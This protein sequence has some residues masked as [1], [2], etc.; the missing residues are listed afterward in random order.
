MVSGRRL[1]VSTK[2]VRA[3][4]RTPA[5]ARTSSSN[6]ADP[7]IPCTVNLTDI[8][9]L[10]SQIADLQNEVVKIKGVLNTL[11][12]FTD[13]LTAIAAMMQPKDLMESKHAELA[14]R[15]I[16]TICTEVMDRLKCLNEVVIYNVP[17]RLPLQ[18]IRKILM[19]VCGL[20]H[21]LLSCT[22]LRKKVMKNQCPL[23]VKFDNE[24][25]ALKFLSYQGEYR[26][27]TTFLDLKLVPA[28]T[29]LQRR[30]DRLT[31][32]SAHSRCVQATCDNSPMP[33]HLSDSGTVDLDISSD[34]DT[35]SLDC[36]EEPAN[37][38]T[39][40]IRKVTSYIE[41][42]SQPANNI[43]KLSIYTKCSATNTSRSVKPEG[44]MA[45]EP[46]RQSLNNSV[47]PM[48][49]KG[50]DDRSELSITNTQRT[51]PPTPRAKRPRIRTTPPSSPEPLGSTPPA[52]KIRKAETLAPYNAACGNGL[53]SALVFNVPDDISVETFRR[54]IIAVNGIAENALQVQRLT[55]RV[56][57][58]AGPIKLNAKDEE[59]LHTLIANRE[60]LRSATMLS[61]LTF[62]PL[63]RS[64][65][66]A[67][68]NPNIIAGYRQ[69][70]LGASKKRQ[71]ATP[72]RLDSIVSNTTKDPNVKRACG[73]NSPIHSPTTAM[74]PTQALISARS[75][76]KQSQQPGWDNALFSV[77]VFNVP[78]GVSTGELQSTILKVNGIAEN[79]V[80][81][82]RMVKRISKFPA[83][84]KLTVDD[85]R[86]LRTV[87]LNCEQLRNA[88]KLRQLYFGP[89]RGR[90]PNHTPDTCE[91]A[92]RTTTVTNSP[93]ESTACDNLRSSDQLPAHPGCYVP[94]TS[95]RLSPPVQ[96]KWP[97]SPLLPTPQPAHFLGQVGMSRDSFIPTPNSSSPN[98]QL[99]CLLTH[100]LQLLQIAK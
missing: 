74:S 53:C 60:Q 37:S 72:N 23:L 12:P 42:I 11:E 68:T 79:S 48:L 87:I 44:P 67:A 86:I 55:K 33:V 30:Y 82:E 32:S 70:E 1:N 29:A 56:T 90:L 63:K 57:Q 100:F 39:S 31:E 22:R 54:A 28:R 93:T 24:S 21:N 35:G 62:G 71:R 89:P 7:T 66:L 16:N 40:A 80:H 17:D 81:V 18:A 83:P 99:Q 97:N 8:F 85:S 38:G 88:L 36:L 41:Q 96:I 4:G 84:V 15:F 75:L 25:S 2:G 51:E 52:L 26:T 94:A 58:F 27:R 47:K 65:G 45:A 61:Q 20:E 69:S 50:D 13:R 73:A 64:L 10:S 59:V 76:D 14:G 98:Y 34:M 3:V 43:R 77:L 49:A 78:D 91:T 92:S 19:K 9:S 6:L 46:L 5:K 95:L